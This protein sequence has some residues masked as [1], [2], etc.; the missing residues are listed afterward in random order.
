MSVVLYEVRDQIAYITL[1]RPDKHNAI[2]TEVDDA[3]FEAW[4]A[5][6]ADDEARV[7]ILS[8]NGRNFCAGA[9]LHDHVDQW[10][11]AGPELGRKVLDKGFA[12]RITRGLHRT[13]KPIIAAL[14]GWI[15]GGGIELCL[16]ADMR[17]CADDANFGF[18]HMRRG[19][20]FGDG[21]IVR[22]VNTC[23]VGIAM[24]LELLGE[25]ITAERAL[26]VHLVNRLV[27]AD[28]VMATAEDMA[29]KI[30]RNPRSAVESA[31]DT[32]LEVIGRQLDDQLRIEALYSYSVM[33]DPEIHEKKDEFLER[34]DADRATTR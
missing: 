32:I 6:A 15:I 28:E 8:G 19:M 22:L 9:D 29:R 23:G 11:E 24:E 21:G 17:V 31:K 14:H 30:I 26:Q 2:S 20:H 5:F 3:L 16:A 18:F 7:A 25:P 1:N 33:G 4:S 27:P 34:R 13:P 10:L 12:G